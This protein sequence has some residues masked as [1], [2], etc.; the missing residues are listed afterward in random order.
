MVARAAEVAWKQD[1]YHTVEDMAYKSLP[2]GS[3]INSRR[4]FP[5][6]TL[7]L[8][9]ENNCNFIHS[10]QLNIFLV[11]NLLYQNYKLNCLKYAPYLVPFPHISPTLE[12]KPSNRIYA[13]VRV[14]R[15]IWWLAAGM[16]ERGSVILKGEVH[17]VVQSIILSLSLS[18][19]HS[20]PHVL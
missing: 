19:S 13:E 8:E 20:T 7:A 17:S 5:I 2:V 18:L 3:T 1:W 14:A 4:K 10:G 12:T 15:C 16:D 11:C 9:K 6:E